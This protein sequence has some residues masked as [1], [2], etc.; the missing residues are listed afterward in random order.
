MGGS[1]VSETQGEAGLE[2]PFNLIIAGVG[3]QGNVL[4]IRLLGS[5]LLAQGY[6]VAV[7]EVYG[8]AQRGGSVASHLRFWK[9]AP[10]PPKVP[11]G[12]LD[13]LLGFEPLE[14]LR[15]LTQYGNPGTAVL[16]NA[17]PVLPIGALLGKF[18]YPD[19]SK[20]LERMRG[21]AQPVV[22]VDAGSVSRELGVPQAMNTVMVG[23]LAGSELLPISAADLE[24]QIDLLMNER[25]R[26]VNHEAFAAG[27]R[28]AAKAAD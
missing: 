22:T 2:R 9:G 28:A 23:A 5:A 17:D 1:T 3:G 16:V 7:G 4:A 14:A 12:Q 25:V 20:L 6:E 8:L 26:N 27:V 24:A 19:V 21:L 11:E 15:L 13:I 10:R 18:D